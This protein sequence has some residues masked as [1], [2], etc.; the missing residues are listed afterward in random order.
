MRPLQGG[1]R[2]VVPTRRPSRRVAA[3]RRVL[4]SV[5]WIVL[6]ALYIRSYGPGW[7]ALCALV[8]SSVALG[9]W[10]GEALAWGDRPCGDE[11][12]I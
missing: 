1:V 9:A 4:L 11:P 2:D 7:L 10:L 3:V 12:Q 8:V 5:G 6:S